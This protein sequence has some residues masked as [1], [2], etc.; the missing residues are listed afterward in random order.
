MEDSDNV[1][2]LNSKEDGCTYLFSPRIG[3]WQKL[4]DIKSIGDMPEDVVDQLG[5]LEASI[6]VLKQQRIKESINV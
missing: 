1:V 2:Q 6:R 4:C 3:K 5:I